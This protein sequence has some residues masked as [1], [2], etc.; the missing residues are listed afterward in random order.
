MGQIGSQRTCGNC[1]TVNAAGEQFC[2]N[3][4]Y[5]LAGGPTKIN[6]N[7]SAA[8]SPNAPLPS[9]SGRRITG[10]LTSGNLLGGRYRIVRL[11][12]KGGF[13]AV[14]EARDER[15][16]AR[17]VVAIKEMSDGHLSPTERAQA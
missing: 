8:A 3:C 13:G 17:R 1:G 5:S 2:V 10:A 14:Y 12:G 9:S 11:V 7:I 4:G 16:Q 6:P 15:F